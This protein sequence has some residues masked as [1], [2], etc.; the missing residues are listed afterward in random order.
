MVKILTYS[1]DRGLSEEA[2][3]HSVPER[4]RER[5]S[6]VWLDFENPG[7]TDFQ[8]LKETFHFHPLALEDS[9][10]KFNLPKIDNYEDYVFL[11]WH[12][13]IE[14]FESEEATTAE[15]DFFVGTNYLV[16]IHNEKI[17]LLDKVYQRSLKDPGLLKKGIDWILHTILDTLVD[18]YFPLLDIISNKIDL[19]EDEIF[20]NPLPDHLRSLFTH[21]HQLLHLRKIIS[22]E[23]EIIVSLTH[24]N[25]SFIREHV[26]IYFADI[27][28]HLI[29]IIDLIDTDRDVIS[30]AMDI[31]LSTISNRLNE[32]MKKLTIVAFV[33]M[34]LTLISGIYEMNFRNMPELTWRY[35]YY[36]VLLLMVIIAFSIIVYFKKVKWW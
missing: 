29:R 10:T 18:G 36:A 6:I 19:L 23:R 17:L 35:G 7:D 24:Y 33:F 12:A 25:S 31:Y 28:D 2:D 16:S 3:L 11:I 9:R 13:F 5:D 20:E 34:P 14:E 30:G 26:Q 15:V 27:H 4:L 32:V 21:K 22:P 8:F 1:L